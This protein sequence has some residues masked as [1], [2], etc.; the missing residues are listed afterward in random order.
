[1]YSQ[2]LADRVCVLLVEGVSL[3][4][5]SK[6]DGMPSLVTFFTWTKKYPEF[7]NKY[8][9][10]RNFR[11]EL[12]AEILIDMADEPLIGRKTRTVRKGKTVKREVVEG[13][14]VERAK[15]KV[16]TRQ[17]VVSKLLPKKYGNQPESTGSK[18]RLEDLMKAKLAALGIKQEL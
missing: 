18:D 9:D 4:K 13:D 17:W 11:A 7:L 3:N 2:E 5:I 12:D 16:N 10:A 6:M 15:L 14:N 8:R 1:M